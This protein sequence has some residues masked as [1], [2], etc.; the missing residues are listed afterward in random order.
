MFYVMRSP[1]LHFREALELPLAL[2]TQLKLKQS[3]MFNVFCQYSHL[4]GLLLTLTIFDWL[5]GRGYISLLLA[6]ADNYL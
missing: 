6:R 1:L 4:V 5:S 3:D 2:K